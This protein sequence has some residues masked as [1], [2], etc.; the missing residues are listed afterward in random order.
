MK[1]ELLVSELGQLFRTNH[2][3][4]AGLGVSHPRLER[5]RVL[6]DERELGFTKLTGGGGGGCAISL[7]SAFDRTLEKELLDEGFEVHETLLGAKGVGVWEEGVMAPEVFLRVDLESQAKGW[8]W[9][10]WC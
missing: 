1:K 9:R 3:L 6:I 4:L 10:Y 2:C 8:G 5:I 7:I